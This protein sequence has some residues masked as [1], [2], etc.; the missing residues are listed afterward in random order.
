MGVTME[1]KYLIREGS[2]LRIGDL[3]VRLTSNA[4]VTSHVD[5]R[6]LGFHGL[7]GISAVEVS[8][9]DS[10]PFSCDNRT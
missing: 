9:N 2:V 5:L 7:V 1:H 10:K 6:I 3:E 4:V 8:T